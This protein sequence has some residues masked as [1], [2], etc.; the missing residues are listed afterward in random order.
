N[1]D[2]DWAIARLNSDGSLDTSFS[3]DGVDAFDWGG[4]SDFAH[5][6]T[7]QGDGKIVV[8]GRAFL[9]PGYHLALAR[10]NPDGSLDQ[11]CNGI[12]KIGF[13]VLPGVYDE[14][15]GVDLQPDGRL[16]AN[17]GYNTDMR[18]A[19]FILNGAQASDTVTITETDQP[20]SHFV[21]G[22]PGTCTE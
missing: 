8:A 20:A 19:R 3:S 18:I 9:P 16:A 7:V 22:A 12:G 21:L 13:R 10:Y 4:Y 1:I 6:V 17:A 14:I 15:W 11:S 5:D 2:D